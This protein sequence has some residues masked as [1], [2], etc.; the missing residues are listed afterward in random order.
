MRAVT[1]ARTCL[2]A[3]ICLTAVGACRRVTIISFHGPSAPAIDKLV[4]NLHGIGMKH[5]QELHGLD[6]QLGLYD[7]PG[8]ETTIDISAFGCFKGF[9][10]LINDTPPVAG[11]YP[12]LSDAVLVTMVEFPASDQ[13]ITCPAVDSDGGV[14]GE[15]TGAGGAADSG[16]GGSAAGMGGAGT[17]G[18]LG[19]VPGI[20]GMG[21]MDGGADAAGGA[22]GGTDAG[23]GGATTCVE[24]TGPSP[25]PSPVT[26][27]APCVDYCN[28][29]I[30]SVDGGPPLCAGSYE[31]VDQC[32]Q[33]CTRAAWMAGTAKD[34]ADSMACRMYA[35]SQI[36]PVHMMPSALMNLCKEAGPSGA[37]SRLD[38]NSCGIASA[39]PGMCT[40]FCNALA[41][42]CP[43][44]ASSC[45]TACQSAPSTQPAC[46]FPWLAHAAS[47]QRYCALVDFGGACLPPGC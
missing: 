47:D 46:R 41:K 5:S 38:P 20:G 1:H 43:D 12:I 45:I 10:Q 15:P 16:S 4:V 7:L 27:S 24:P 28:Q 9:I 17:G 19:G 3:I 36:D 11:G 31:S 42:I 14:S 26:P 2:L 32:R 23:D 21:G 22:G 8:S 39:P 34:M 13:N 35:L 6:E 33:Y 37:T 18:G 40:T 44:N 29:I 30:G 25:G